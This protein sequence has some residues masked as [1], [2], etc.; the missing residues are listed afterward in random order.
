MSAQNFMAIHRIVVEIIM[1]GPKW[2]NHAAS[3]AKNKDDKGRIRRGRTDYLGVEVA[4][5]CL[6]SPWLV[7]KLR[8][9]LF[10]WVSYHICHGL[11]TE[12]DTIR[13]Y[14]S[15]EIAKD[16][17]RINKRLNQTYCV[18][19]CVAVEAASELWTEFVQFHRDLAEQTLQVG[20]SWSAVN[21]LMDRREAS[22]APSKTYH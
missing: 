6:L 9:S 8:S 3:M 1:F 22:I 17:V 2:H 21:R 14:Y 20:D 16:P 5:H 13:H 7:V 12:K 19:W 4:T 11:W 18:D 15:W 10:F